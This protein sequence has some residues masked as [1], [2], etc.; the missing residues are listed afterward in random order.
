L[1]AEVDKTY[2]FFFLSLI[3]SVFKPFPRLL[4]MV[5]VFLGKKFLLQPSLASTIFPV[6]S[7][8]FGIFF[9]SVNM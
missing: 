3:N 8:S 2:N 4:Y 9:S 7:Q 1:S 5:T 6:I